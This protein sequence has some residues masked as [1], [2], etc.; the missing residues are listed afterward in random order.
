MAIFR[1]SGVIAGRGRLDSDRVRL[2]GGGLRQRELL[3]SQGGD[4]DIQ[5]HAISYIFEPP[6]PSNPV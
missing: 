2:G 4:R 1:A 3:I 5:V 6:G